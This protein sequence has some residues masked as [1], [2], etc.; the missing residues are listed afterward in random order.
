MKTLLIITTC[1]LTVSLLPAQELV[2]NGSFEDPD[3]AL[4]HWSIWSPG[5][6]KGEIS[7][8]EAQQGSNSMK[9]TT[10]G[11]E[12]SY[13]GI[14]QEEIN[15]AA[16]TEYVMTFWI[17]G[18]IPSRTD[19]EIEAK[20]PTGGNAESLGVD[21][22]NNSAP[23]TADNGE[24]VITPG[25]Y[26]NWTKVTYYWNS[27]DY[28]RHVID[29]G[30]YAGGTSAVYYLDNFSIVP[31]T[32]VSVADSN[33]GT[34][35]TFAMHQ[36]YPNP[37]NPSTKI[38]FSI[39]STQ[40]VK[41]EVYNQVGQKVETLVDGFMQAGSY[42]AEFNAKTLPSGMYFYRINAGRYQDMKKMLL[43]K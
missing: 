3:F 38:S 8:E 22:K 18:T 40:H 34:P 30:S 32:T 13:V 20:P 14:Y 21:S 19:G 25:T 23:I 43:L 2:K 12:T 29:L 26:D 37:F 17:K 10:S 33:P 35:Y 1:I 28:Y 5:S 36:N 27:S 16:N 4:E 6:G 39:P 11:F 41:L 9:I 31:S 42:E 24:F 7:T 15:P